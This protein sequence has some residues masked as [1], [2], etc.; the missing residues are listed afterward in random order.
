MNY[1]SVKLIFY[2][3]SVPLYARAGVSF[4]FVRFALLYCTALLFS[5]IATVVFHDQRAKHH[6]FAVD[7]SISF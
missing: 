2:F 6:M 4:F 3:F 5:E 1:W 7:Y